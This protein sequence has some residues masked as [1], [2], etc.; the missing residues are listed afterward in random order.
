MSESETK[1]ADQ[2]GKFA[3]VVKDGQKLPDIEWITGR[4]LL[5]NKRIILVSNEGKRTIEL[6]SVT[7]I[8]GRQDAS[9]P[10]AD[11]SSY[12]SIQQGKDVTLVS[13]KEHVT[14]ETALYRAVL[15]QEVVAIKHPAVE[16]GVVQ[17]TSWSKGQATLDFE[18]VD[19]TAEGMVGLATSDGQFV[20]IDVSDVGM[21]EQTEGD[22]MGNERRIIEVEHTE[23]GT[24][25]E[26]HISGPSQKVLVLT[27]LLRKG[28]EQNT[29]EVE[30]SDEENAVLMA[31][32]SG[33]SPFQIPEFVGM[34]VDQ[35][36]ET[37]DQLIEDG[38]LE[39]RRVRREVKLKARGRHIASEA[40]GEE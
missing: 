24:A 39:E 12:L 18:A 8:K 29:T 33:I 21:V 37:F 20:E 7:G 2:P 11:V 9:N 35:V 17:S 31:L 38:I 14:F 1:L 16:G 36:E 23:D 6:A 28:E 15:D 27:S 30:L 10:L 3:M 19:R 32:Y 26:T 4:I 40:M 13:P 25:V 5:S 22:V 34:D